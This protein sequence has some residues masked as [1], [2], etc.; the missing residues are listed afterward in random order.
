MRDGHLLLLYKSWEMATSN[1]LRRYGNDKLP[2]LRRD[3]VGA[4]TFITRNSIAS[5]HETIESSCKCQ[6]WT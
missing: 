6:A 1:P 5:D 4:F 3:K 2:F